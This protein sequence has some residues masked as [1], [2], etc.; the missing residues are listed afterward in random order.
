MGVLGNPDIQIGTDNCAGAQT[1][2]H[3]QVV[4]GGYS[5]DFV[6]AV[7]NGDPD[8]CGTPW[9][10]EPGHPLH[11]I[12]A[13]GS[14]V[15][16]IGVVGIGAADGGVGLA[17]QVAQPNSIP[18]LPPGVNNTGQSDVGY[19]VCGVTGGGLSGALTS[20]GLGDETPFGGVL[21]YGDNAGVV[22]IAGPQGEE[23]PP[24]SGATGVYGRGGG[25]DSSPF[26]AVGVYGEAGGGNNNGVQGN[27]SGTA[28]GVAG[29]GE[30]GGVGV[31]GEGGKGVF[32][33]SSEGVGVYGL[34]GPGFDNN[35]VEGH[36]SG[37]AA[38]VAG[39]GDGAP[40]SA[41]SGAVGVFG[42]AGAGN[43]NGVEGHGSG[44]S[45]GVAGFGVPD[46]G[47][48]IQ[49]EG[50]YGIQATGSL[51]GVYASSPGSTF[52]GG[53]AG[54]FDGAVFVHGVLAVSGPK[55]AA[56]PHQDGSHRLLYS[57]ESPESWFED[58]GESRLVGGKARVKL[59]PGFASVV[60]ANSFHVFLTSYGDSNGLYVSQRNKQGFEVR[61]QGN[62]ESNVRFSYRIVAK[63]KDIKGERLAK[64]S[65]PKVM[66]KP[67]LSKSPKKLK[68]AAPAL[69]KRLATV[70]MPKGKAKRR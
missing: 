17:G 57:I 13:L 18:Q 40:N 59:E 8:S 47:I 34:A 23:P 10:G 64:I 1:S 58:F 21:G 29:F 32:G 3:A 48:G 61:E 31:F 2:L 19:G 25:A 28:A 54:Y 9:L 16:G 30:S 69:P 12:R 42:Q 49:G 50:L 37:T 35:G 55:A 22:G 39:F 62:G 20:A 66:S 14:P 15:G 65:L 6:F 41:P 56:V 27:G 7:D 45:A 51:I 4:P 68:Q 36:G 67:P 38:G 63:R 33:Y 44:T 46:R 11:A 24:P 26:S 52:L 70:T 5:G 60:K 43:S 53:I